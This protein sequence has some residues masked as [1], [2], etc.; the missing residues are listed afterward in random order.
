VRVLLT[1]DRVSPNAFFL[2]QRKYASKRADIITAAISDLEHA[3][4]WS[5]Q[6][7]QEVAGLISRL[8]GVSLV[9]EE[10]T[11]ARTAYGVAFLTDEVMAQQQ[12]TADI[13]QK[14]GLIPNAVAVKDAV[15]SPP[16]Q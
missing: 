4:R 10:R 15:W 8:T 2:A 3:S 16:S 9:A 11:V 6:H 7:Q 13:L 5:Q 12:E 14:L 1:G